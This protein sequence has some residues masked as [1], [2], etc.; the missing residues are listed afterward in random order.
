L[1][2]IYRLF[3]KD[4]LDRAARENVRTAPQVACF[5][6]D[7]IGRKIMIDGVFEKRELLA[8]ERFLRARP[9]P[10]ET[11]L[12]VGAN[13]GNHALFLARIFDRVIAFEPNARTFRLLELN[14]EL[15]PNVRAVHL[16]LSDRSAELPVA[17][18]RLNIGGAR[19]TTGGKVDTTFQ[20]VPLDEYLRDLPDVR[21]SFVKMDVEGHELHALRG[22]RAMLKRDRPVLALEMEF[23]KE[24]GMNGEV[25]DLLEELGYRR[26]HLLRRSVPLVGTPEFRA[27]AMSEFR[28][29]RPRDHKMVLFTH[30]AEAVSAP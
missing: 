14:A 9:G 27:M 10:R 4:G 15:A 24:P 3:L 28:K 7:I 1:N 26:A 21:V 17:V 18:D 6:H 5:A 22:G 20:V 30:D 23:R 13:I 25:L 19:I 29:L 12:D 2:P 16:G 11:C 8:L